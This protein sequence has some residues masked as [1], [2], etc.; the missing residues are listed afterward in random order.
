M[1]QLVVCGLILIF[2][3]QAK[4]IHMSYLGETSV[5]HS[6][7]FNQTTIGGLSAIIWKDGKLIALSDDKGTVGEPRFYEFDLKVEFQKAKAA[8][9]LS[10]NS[11]SFITGLPNQSQVPPFLDTEGMVR[12]SNGDFLISSEGNNDLKP[13]AMPRIFRM[14]SDGKWKSDITIP[15]KYLPEPIGQQKKGIQNNLAFEGLTE[16]EDGK[17]VFTSTEASLEQDAATSSEIG[18]EWIRILKYEEKG[19]QG[20]QPVAEFAYKLDLGPSSQK[21]TEI[22]RGVSEIL[23][24][25]N[26]KLLVLERGIRVTPKGSWS[27]T[28]GI[29]LADLSKG[30]DVTSLNKLADG[31]F[32]VVDKVK[33]IDFETDLANE[34]SG[35][36]VQNF[37]ALAW[38]P[39]LPDGRRSLLVM[40][41][42]NFSKKE[43]TELLLFAVEGD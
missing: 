15:E 23:A 24:L 26:S 28:V 14:R 42:N 19:P 7:K 2:T 22:F 33:L 37:E 20:Y 25:S 38:G 36:A 12:L 43:I 1:G 9:Q 34:R 11:V 13:R 31:K 40:S 27:N 3:L 29:Y 5:A 21:G 6:L 16:F 4:A 17:F 32:I 41:D 39:K 35:K 10:P 8:L 18:G 30:T